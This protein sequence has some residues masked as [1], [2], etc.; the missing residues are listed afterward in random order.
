M[1]DT[2]VTGHGDTRGD[3]RGAYVR[4][5]LIVAVVVL[6]ADQVSKWAILEMFDKPPHVLEVL[7]VFNLVLTWNRGI[8]FGLF[9]NTGGMGPW[10]L[11]GVAVVIAAI[12]ARWLMR[13]TSRWSALGLGLVIGGALGNVIDRVRFGAVVDFLDVHVLG[14]HWP[15]FNV[16]DSAITVGAGILIVES[17][18]SSRE[19]P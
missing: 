9:G 3:T 18:F 10:I 11:T 5:G 6:I 2:P 15:A 14:Y 8:S 1:N 19:T 17:L 12:L 7:P 16:A 4:F 13:T